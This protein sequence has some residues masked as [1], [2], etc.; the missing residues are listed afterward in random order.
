MTAAMGVRNNTFADTPEMRHFTQWL[1]PA[2]RYFYNP[3]WATEL[4][5][6][7]EQLCLLKELPSPLFSIQP[8]NLKSKVGTDEP[9]V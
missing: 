9:R 4:P 5:G 3:R 6:A 1:I 7:G 8:T 2:V